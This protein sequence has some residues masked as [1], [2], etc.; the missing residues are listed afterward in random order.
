MALDFCSECLV[1]VYNSM[2]I[3]LSA[4]YL[5]VEI[6]A[7]DAKTAQHALRK[8]PTEVSILNIPDSL[9]ATSSVFPFCMMYKMCTTAGL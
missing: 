3:G 9:T 4:N 5:T 6:Q 8:S 2:V 1:G 7:A